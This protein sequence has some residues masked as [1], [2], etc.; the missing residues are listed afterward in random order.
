MVSLLNVIQL[1]PS[2]EGVLCFQ[3]C[4]LKEKVLFL[5]IINGPDFPSGTYYW[6][7]VNMPIEKRK[8]LAKPKL[9]IYI[10]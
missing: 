8:M 5:R 2:L 7:S 6:C 3:L 1:I 9:M 4:H 10:L